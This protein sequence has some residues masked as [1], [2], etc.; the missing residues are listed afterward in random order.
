[1]MSSR[2]YIQSFTAR[3]GIWILLANVLSKG[4]G[5]ASIVFVTRSTTE[6]AFGSYAFSF[7]II[8]AVVPFMGLGAYQAFLRFSADSKG[9]SHK[10]LLYEYAFTWGL[11]ISILLSLSIVLL[12]P[13]L[14]NDLPNSISSLQI[15]AWVIPTTLCME[16][17]KS[18]ARAMHLNALSARVDLTYSLVLPVLTVF[19]T[20]MLGITGYALAITLS[21]FIAMWPYGYRLGLYGIRWKLQMASWSPFWKYGVFTAIG[22]LLSQLFYAIDLYMIGEFRP[23]HPEVIAAYRVAAII[24]LASLILPGSVAATDFVK[25]AQRAN[26]RSALKAYV[27]QY[28]R[29]FGLLSVVL[30]GLIW[31]MAPSILGIFGNQYVAST[32]LLRILLFG[33]VGAHLLRVPFGNLLSAVGKATW[34]TY[35]N[36]AVLVLTVLLCGVLLP[37]YEIEGAALAMSIMMWFSGLLNALG[38]W[39]YWRGLV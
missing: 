15:V 7:N 36:I 14:C 28:W 27:F 23:D 30:L 31:V 8:N 38:F 12:S 19:L 11:V 22:A 3:K 32:S 18:Y 4:M 1:M 34:N 6:E 24:P 33:S 21:P 35:I 29:T 10:K 37:L 2:E 25:N 17:V 5:F 39:W 16:F 26:N 13:W 20:N 9:L